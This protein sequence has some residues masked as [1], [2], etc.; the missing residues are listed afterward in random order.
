MHGV[1]KNVHMVCASPTMVERQVASSVEQCSP[2]GGDVRHT[3]MVLPMN[4]AFAASG[5]GFHGCT[6]WVLATNLH[7]IPTQCNVRAFVCPTV[8][9]FAC[10]EA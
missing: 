10:I 6:I 4:C 2:P 5:H 8:T 7:A 1:H 9:A 3:D